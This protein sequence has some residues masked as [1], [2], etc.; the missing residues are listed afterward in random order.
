MLLNVPMPSMV[1]CIGISGATPGQT[2]KLP[3]SFF[4]RQKLHD[5][6]CR[7]RQGEMVPVLFTE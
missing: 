5:S 4:M 6:G 2:S 3:L 7:P 1:N